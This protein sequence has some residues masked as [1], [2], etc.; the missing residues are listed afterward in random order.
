MNKTQREIA[1]RLQLFHAGNRIFWSA[2]GRQPKFI[3][4]LLSEPSEDAPDDIAMN[5]MVENQGAF[6]LPAAFGEEIIIV[7]SEAD[8]QG[9]QHVCLAHTVSGQPVYEGSVQIIVDRHG[10]VTAFKDNRRAGVP[11]AREKVVCAD[12]DRKEVL[13]LLAAYL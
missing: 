9:C 3:M 2:D 11:A 4:G 1:E 13:G 7:S 12:E 5:F 10:V 6:A 8:D